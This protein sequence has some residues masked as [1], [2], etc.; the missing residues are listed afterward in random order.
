L[1]STA[2]LLP[3]SQQLAHRLSQLAKGY[4]LN[5]AADSMG[6]IGEF[7]AVGMDA[8]LSDL[9]HAHVHLVGRD[10]P[11]NKTVRI[12]HG[13]RHHDG[14]EEGL[15][16]STGAYDE[17]DGEVPKPTLDSLR[18]LLTLNPALHANTSPALYRLSSGV[19][20]AEAEYN[21]PPVK[22]ELVGVANG[23]PRSARGGDAVKERKSERL[24]RYLENGMIK[25]DATK[26]ERKDKKHSLH[27]KYE[28][29]ALILESV[30]G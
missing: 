19:T 24:Q 11:G 6:D 21:A 9:L 20:C 14:E 26:E 16:G 29:P 23:Y 5:I 4:D 10:R 13:T 1:A 2:R 8:H 17:D 28:D 18:S 7:L 3:S 25:V 27:W 12:P 30:L 15:S 22:H